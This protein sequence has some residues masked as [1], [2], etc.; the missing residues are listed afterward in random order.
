M[1]YSQAIALARADND[2]AGRPCPDLAEALDAWAADLAAGREL[3][4]GADDFLRCLALGWPE[5][6]ENMT[7]LERG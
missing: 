4:E 1:T 7:P 6:R 2:S 3:S 5:D